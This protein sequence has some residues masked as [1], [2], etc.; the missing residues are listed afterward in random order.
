MSGSYWINVPILSTELEAIA[1]AAGIRLRRVI[2]RPEA[3]GEVLWKAEGDNHL[4][5]ARFMRFIRDAVL[6]KVKSQDN[7]VLMK[8]TRQPTR[9][10]AAKCAAE[11]V[12]PLRT[13]GRCK[14]K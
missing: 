1:R 12:E 3:E 10:C 7:D 8:E 5:L 4:A 11:C 2:A 9:K 13:A 6:E 14:D